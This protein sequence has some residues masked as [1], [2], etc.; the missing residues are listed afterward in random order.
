MSETPTPENEKSRRS[1]SLG[2][3][4]V[5]LL[6]V[7]FVLVVMGGKQ[8]HPVDQLSQDQYEWH[9]NQGDIVSQKMRGKDKS[10][11]RITGIYHKPGEGEV[12]FEVSYTSLNDREETFRELKARTYRAT[13]PAELMAGIEAGSYEP[14]GVRYLTGFR[15]TQPGAPDAEGAKGETETTENGE[16]PAEPAAPVLERKE[17]LLVAVL[18]R[19]GRGL[20]KPGDID[21]DVQLGDGDDPAA[22]LGTFEKAGV[23]VER[24]TYDLT[25]QG[26]TRWEDSSSMLGTFLMYVGPWILLMVVFMI[27]LRQM[28]SQGGAGGVMSF[29]RS[30]AQLYSKESHTNVTFD[31]VAGARE[32]KDEVRE[33][34]EFLKN[35]SRFTRIGGRIP[36][37]VLLVGPPGCGKTLL[38]KAI[39]GEAEVPFFSISG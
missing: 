17:K 1:R 37:G 18:D 12:P 5:F 3:F 11:N 2:S 16:K 38:A 32:A 24:R 4:L 35:P 8:M 20:D 25:D 34:V 19:S 33:I 22:L 13:S 14:I 7:F 28:R 6:V 21:Y 26:G 29:G 31:D 30:R 15:R 9:L 27:F 39:A 23:P 10:T 36:R